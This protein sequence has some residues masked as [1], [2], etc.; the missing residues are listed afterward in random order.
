MDTSNLVLTGFVEH[1]DRALQEAE[2]LAR[3]QRELDAY[4]FDPDLPVPVTAIETE[5]TEPRRRRRP[6]PGNR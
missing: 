3:W 2:D 6:A 1:A 4:A 5:A